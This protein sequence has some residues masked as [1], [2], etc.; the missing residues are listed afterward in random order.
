M[1]GGVFPGVV[2]LLGSVGAWLVWLVSCE[3]ARYGALSA[4]GV[5][6]WG[7]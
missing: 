1:F 2:G 4:L 3:F 5:A 7:V 6:C